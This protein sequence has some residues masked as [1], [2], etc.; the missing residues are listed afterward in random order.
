MIFEK[1]APF[2]V[3]PEIA[4]GLPDRTG[5][6]ADDGLYAAKNAGRAPVKEHHA[7]L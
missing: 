5:Y 1:K 4:T 2:A 6:V 3:R 7:P